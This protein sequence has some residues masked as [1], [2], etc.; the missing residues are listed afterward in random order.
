MGV[1][2]KIK[3][4]QVDADAFA[5]QAKE[6]GPPVG[7]AMRQAADLVMRVVSAVGGAL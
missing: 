5:V 1:G 4:D 6:I 7:L 2:G 3:L